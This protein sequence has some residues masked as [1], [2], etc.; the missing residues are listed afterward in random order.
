VDASRTSACDR[1]LAAAE[2]SLADAVLAVRLAVRDQLAP[3]SDGDSEID[4]ATASVIQ[5]VETGADIIPGPIVPASPA[6]ERDLAVSVATQ[7]SAV[8]TAVVAA[9]SAN[10]S[11]T[12]GLDD[13]PPS[14]VRRVNNQTAVSAALFTVMWPAITSFSFAQGVPAVHYQSLPQTPQ[15]I[16][17]GGVFAQ[18]LAA[19]LPCGLKIN[20]ITGV[21]NGTAIGPSNNTVHIIAISS[22][23]ALATVNLNPFAL[24]VTDCDNE[25][26]CNGG[27]CVD[28]V[29]FDGVF[30]C[31]CSKA[32]LQGGLTCNIA[33]VSSLQRGEI[34][35]IAAAVILFCGMLVAGIVIHVVRNQ[36][37]GNRT[38]RIRYLGPPYYHGRPATADSYWR[39]NTLLRGR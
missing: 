14:R 22:E 38:V 19:N 11:P 15:A 32:P 17:S 28:D 1:Q 36:V 2:R 39:T 8:P 13:A 20:P 29:R 27:R 16:V 3:T 6:A 31:D 5:N 30:E 9:T 33:V 18:Y 35:A 4:A 12:A 25:L 23:G 21:I 26:S 34:A 7:F 10:L 24:I 37:R